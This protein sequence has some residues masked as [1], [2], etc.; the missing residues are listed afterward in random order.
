M[1]KIVTSREKVDK[2]DGPFTPGA[3]KMFDS[4]IKD[5][6][7]YQVLWSGNEFYQVNGLTGEQCVVDLQKKTYACRRW[8]I[9]GM[10]YRHAVASIWNMADNSGDVGVPEHWVDPVYLKETWR[11]TYDFTIKP[12][13]GSS[14]WIK[15][16][17]TKLLPL[18]NVPQAGRPKKSRRKGIHENESM[19]TNGKLSR[20]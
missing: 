20:K 18:I 19:V 16:N 6:H 8:E 12:I 4:I 14:M 9:T 10:P 2:C 11:N 15:P 5:A 13:N 3:K 7:K 1:K 17:A